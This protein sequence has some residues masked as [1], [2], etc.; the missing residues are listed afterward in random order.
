MEGRARG[1]PDH[2]GS[3]LRVLE[4]GKDRLVVH[5][6]QCRDGIVEL[7]GPLGTGGDHKRPGF[8]ALEDPLGAVMSPVPMVTRVS[9]SSETAPPASGPK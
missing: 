6:R 5:A 4:C 7:V 1:A 2:G 8:G 3:G 9:A